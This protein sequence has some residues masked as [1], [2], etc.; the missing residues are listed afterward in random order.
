MCVG[1]GGGLKK[2]S[3]DSRIGRKRQS[4]GKV[5][6]NKGLWIMTFIQP[7]FIIVFFFVR[8]RA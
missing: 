2:Q 6:G 1:G 5:E 8:R 7:T 4:K 3:S